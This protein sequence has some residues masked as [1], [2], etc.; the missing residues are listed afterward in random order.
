MQEVSP[1]ECKRLQLNILINVAKFCE[2]H[3][4]KYSLAYGTL[5]G[6]VRHK[7]FIP[8]DDDI[9][10]IM[11]R[12][13]Y[14]RFVATYKDVSYD[15]V[16]GKH[17]LN[18]MHVRIADK[19]TFLVSLDGVRDKFYKSGVWI[20]VFPIDK[21]PNNKKQ[22][23]VFMRKI[24]WLCKLQRIAEVGGKGRKPSIK[25]PFYILQLFLKP[26]G[27]LLGKKANDEMIKYNHSDS[28][29]VANVSLWYLHYPSFPIDYMKEFATHEFEGCLFH[30][31][32]K[33]DEFL[34][35]IYGD[36]MT[37]P[38]VNMRNYRHGYIAYKR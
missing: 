27:P 24:Y 31:I 11:L 8:W 3:N 7:G 14:E 17:Q 22:Y 21:V 15:M 20:D 1:E 23:K 16:D 13:D 4:I 19:N 32:S 36:Y 12:D 6:A 35:G 28:N 2:E 10:I 33:Y 37:P 38:P 34:K 26:F 9:D 29:T 5:I 18:H 30:I 25:I